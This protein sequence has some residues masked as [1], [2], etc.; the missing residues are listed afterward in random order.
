MRS[1]HQ[2]LEIERTGNEGL[3]HVLEG[4]RFRVAEDAETFEAALDVRRRV[5]R[6]GCGYDVPVPDAYD[7]RSWLLVA[8]HIASG[9]V[10]GTM[11]VTP[12]FAGSIESEQYFDLPLHLRSRHVVEVNRFAILF[13]HRKGAN[14]MPTVSFGLFKLMINFVMELGMKYVVVCSKPERMWTYQW[15]HFKRTGMTASYG[16]LANSDHEMLYMDLR[17]GLRDEVKTEADQKLFDFFFDMSHDEVILPRRIPTIR[18]GAPLGVTE[19]LAR[20][21]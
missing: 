16:S 3:A 10:V 4:Y 15:L 13:K 21:A 20:T 8:E 2:H 18:D 19:P 7:G 5:Y 14:G 12:R 9:E 17:Q 1:R 11:R 6:G